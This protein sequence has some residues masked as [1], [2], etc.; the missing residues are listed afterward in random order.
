M[1]YKLSKSS[2]VTIL[3]VHN[4]KRTATRLKKIIENSK[5]NVIQTATGEEALTIVKKK[6]SIK[7]VMTDIDLTKTMTGIDLADALMKTKEIPILFLLSDTDSKK[8]EK[9][10]EMTHYGFIMEDAVPS[11]I[12]SS[13]QIALELTKSRKAKKKV[14]ISQTNLKSKRNKKETDQKSN[15]NITLTEKRLRIAFNSM[16]NGFALHDIICDQEGKPIDYRFLDVNPAFEKLTGLKSKNIIGKTALEILPHTEAI[17][18]KRYGKVALTGKPIIFENYSQDF[19]KY[20]KVT[21]YSPQK[22]QFAV[23]FEDI[24]E[25][26]QAKEALKESENKYR[27]LY[28]GNVDGII[29]TTLKGKIIDCNK[30]LLNMLGYS[31][32]EIKQMNFN[33][34]TPEKYHKWEKEE[35]IEKQLLQ[36]GYSDIYEK[37]YIRKDGSVF[38]VEIVAYRIED[39]SSGKAIFWGVVRDTTTRKEAEIILRDQK[40]ILQVVLDNMPAGVFMVEAPSGKP[41]LSN[42]MAENILGK[43]ISPDATGD[44]LNKIYQAYKYGTDELYP[45]DEM[46]IVTGLQGKWKTINDM[47]VH[48]NNGERLLLEVSGSPV[49]NE[50][51]EIIA[52]VIVFQN[53]TERKKLELQLARHSENLEELVEERTAMLRKVNNQL[54]GEVRDRKHAEEQIKT[55]LHDKELLLAEVHHRIKNNMTTIASLLSLHAGSRKGSYA[56]EALLDAQSRVLSMMNIYDKLYKSGDYLNIN[57]KQYMTDLIAGIQ[58]TYIISNEKIHIESYID[59]II[60]KTKLSFPIGIIVNELISNAIKHAFPNNKTGF[61]KISTSQPNK[62]SLEI[63]I[64]DNGIGLTTDISMDDSGQFGLF[65]VKTLIEEIEGTVVTDVTNGTVYTITVPL[66]SDL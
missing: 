39:S 50:N 42:I 58:K 63:I 14:S 11:M 31:K 48:R 40:R 4:K 21:A 59:D 10:K 64:S 47:E 65:L 38:P 9:A 53:I 30:S 66:D 28:E 29:S 13:L 25:T 1:E 22:K 37:E 55:L 43:G 18:I 35:I 7:L 17:W 52:S 62:K 6:K 61:I 46:P 36:K 24:T 16:L 15:K 23:I 3:L 8:I 26:K 41:I 5:F 54:V 44:D 34:F 60:V 56:A 20:F 12:L 2:T 27:T 49:F 32:K 51:G 19:N 57:L 45:S 33:D